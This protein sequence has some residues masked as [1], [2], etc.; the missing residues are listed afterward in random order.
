VIDAVA[1]FAHYAAHLR[2]IWDALPES[3]RGG[4]YASR[5]GHPWGPPLRR[6]HVVSDR[7]TLVAGLVDA[8]R[9]PRRPLIYVEHGAGQTYRGDPKSATHA[10]YSGGV[11]GAY[12]NVRLFVCPSETVARRWRSAYPAARVAVVGCPYLDPWHSGRRGAPEDGLVVIAWH[13]DCRVVPEAR[14]AFSHYLPRLRVIV[15]GLRAAGYDVA[16]HAHP[17]AH[18]PVRAVYDDLDVPYIAD[19]A[20]VYDRA[21]VLVADNSSILYEFASLNRPV[22]AL[23]APWYRRDVTHGMRF[24]DLIPGIDVDEPDDV[25]DAVIEAVTDRPS[26][27]A[28]RRRV[29]AAV[30]H[31]ADGRAA[32][33]AAAAVEETLRG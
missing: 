31:R 30:Y 32:A 17:R 19:L 27:A 25:V 23:N 4:F 18:G 29:T 22:V 16:G 6:S 7:P 8:A 12:A 28:S 1:T 20:A 14:S 24:W 10:S 3:A 11:D 15:A 33:R 2:P 21:S 13:W 26:V 9:L 5:S